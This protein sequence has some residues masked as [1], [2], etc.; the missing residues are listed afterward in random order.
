MLLKLNEKLFFLST[1][2]LPCTLISNLCQNGG[3][4]TNDNI[5]G[6]TCTCTVVYTGT[7]C[8]NYGM[9]LKS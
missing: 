2:A 3:T 1:K 7:N 9:L 4:C 5:G 8:E 6:Y